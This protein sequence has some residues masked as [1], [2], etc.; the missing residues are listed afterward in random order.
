MP[1]SL[2]EN[3]D[4]LKRR[5]SRVPQGGILNRIG[6]ADLPAASGETFETRSPTDDSFICAVPRSGAEDIDAAARAAKRAF[7]A[8]RGHGPAKAKGAP[9]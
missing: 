3:L 6:D 1:S 5:L 8:W 4:A 2:S 7:P 9:A